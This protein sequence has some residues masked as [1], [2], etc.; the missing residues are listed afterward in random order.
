MPPEIQERVISE[1]K[2][3]APA[4]NARHRRPSLFSPKIPNIF[5]TKNTPQQQYVFLKG[6]VLFLLKAPARD[7]RHRRPS[8]FSQKNKIQGIR[9]KIIPFSEKVREAK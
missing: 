8:L 4:R 2:K 5:K 7:A 6:D 3:K 1:K 9:T